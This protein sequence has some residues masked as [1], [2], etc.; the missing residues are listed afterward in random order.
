VVVVVVV[1]M[2]VVVHEISSSAN[3][4]LSLGSRARLAKASGRCNFSVKFD[5]MNILILGATGFIGSAAAARLLADGHSVTGL[6]RN[7][8]RARLKLPGIRWI[9]ADLS[10]ML[11]VEDWGAVIEGHDAVV[12][13]A[14]ALQDGLADDL[15]ATQHKAMLA[16]Y[17]AAQQTRPLIVQISA[18]TN[19][20][21]GGLPFLATKR[22]ADKALAAS[23]LPHVILRP[24]LVLGRNAHGGSALLRALAALPFG[25]PLVH[26]ANP[27]ATVA[28]DDVAAAVSRAVAGHLPS[29]T[30]ADLASTE[31]L[32]LAQ[33][34]TLH[35]QWLGLP[36]A[37]VVSLPAVAA[38]PATWVADAA[39]RLGWRSPLRSTAM[40]VM[41]EGIQPNADSDPGIAT[42]SA[43]DILHMNPAGVQ[44]L[45]FARLYLLKP[46]MIGTL[47]IFWLLSGFLPLLDIGRAATHFL[48]LLQAG[49]AASLAVLTCLIDML[50]GAAVLV[51][52]L[53]RRA[54]HGMVLVSLTYLAGATIVEPSL[55]LDPLGPLVKV[56]PSLVL[57][58]A[59]L[60]IL[61]ER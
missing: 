47:S 60:A 56:L 32:T 4:Q 1:M 18:R 55:W 46:L 49:P 58:L 8:S 13:C 34:V 61:D 33:L 12:N 51:R 22:Q 25:I 38:G 45:W 48:P 29:G 7:P 57:T 9:E 36:H 5:A 50:L 14:G 11:R 59:A 6:G 17:D 39:G 35:R 31:Q 10:K 37:N 53:A 42:A 30:D 23:G 41:A 21:A 28:L 52:P 26:A 16:L 44:D 54:M 20:A 27:V 15:A 43:R 3:L 24:A 2:I 19:G 40:T